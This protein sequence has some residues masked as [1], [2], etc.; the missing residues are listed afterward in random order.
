MRA[1]KN[2]IKEHKVNICNFK[3]KTGT[4]TVVFHHF[5]DAR[6]NQA[7]LCWQVLEVVKYLAWG[8]DLQKLN[9]SRS[10]KCFL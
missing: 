5:H 4:D 2:R 7:Q 1:V 6:H 8:G 3:E 10:I 9:D